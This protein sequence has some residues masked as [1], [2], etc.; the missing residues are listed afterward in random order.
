M[1]IQLFLWSKEK[2]KEKDQ[3]REVS[4]NVIQIGHFGLLKIFKPKQ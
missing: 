2:E 3:K 4:Q 1:N